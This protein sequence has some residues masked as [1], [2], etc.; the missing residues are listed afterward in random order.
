[1][2]A[3]RK[4]CELLLTF[5]SEG[6]SEIIPEN[7]NNFPTVYVYALYSFEEQGLVGVIR[8]GGLW[9]VRYD[10]DLNLTS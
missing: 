3:L 8:V 4:V 1:M 6:K 5:K 7:R 9:K 10:R 2:K